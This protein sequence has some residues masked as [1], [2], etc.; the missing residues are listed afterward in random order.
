MPICELHGARFFSKQTHRHTLFSSDRIHGNWMWMSLL[1]I[2]KKK[3]KRIY[4][5]INA[6][7]VATATWM[8]ISPIKK[9]S[10][11]KQQLKQQRSKCNSCK[12]ITVTKWFYIC[13]SCAHGIN[14]SADFE[15][16]SPIFGAIYDIRIHTISWQQ[17]K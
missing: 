15:L 13:I 17:I 5:F 11:M 1:C 2:N 3:N 12:L 7:A 4:N 8:E 6:S 16:I 9:P 10:V 14:Q